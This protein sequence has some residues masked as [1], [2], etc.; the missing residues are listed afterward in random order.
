MNQTIGM[1][2]PGAFCPAQACV[3]EYFTV[4]GLYKYLITQI[5]ASDMFSTVFEKDP[6]DSNAGLRYR[7]TILENGS[8]RDEMQMLVDFLGR[9]PDLN[10]LIARLEP[11]S[12]T[13]SQEASFV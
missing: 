9:R 11:S 7:H 8:S 5:Y 4:E 1:D 13:S 3:P 12:H 2:H 6:R 10:A